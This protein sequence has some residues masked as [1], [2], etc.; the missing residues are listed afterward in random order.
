MYEKTKYACLRFQTVEE[1]TNDS[2][3]NQDN[4]MVMKRVLKLMKYTQGEN[5]KKTTMS[6]IMPVFV[7]IETMES[8]EHFTGQKEN[9][10][11]EVKVMMSLPPE[12]NKLT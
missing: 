9:K 1:P 4:D 5:T 6:F 7:H 11:F 3:S 8:N 10:I 12:V 2:R